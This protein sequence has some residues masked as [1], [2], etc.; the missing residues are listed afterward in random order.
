MGES[1]LI[2]VEELLKRVDGKKSDID[3]KKE[4]TD[5]KIEY[6]SRYV[7]E[8]VRVGVNSSKIHRLNFI[9]C[10]SNSGIYSDGNLSTAACVFEQFCAQAKHHPEKEFNLVINDINPKRVELCTAVCNEL[11]LE[12]DYSGDNLSL[13]TSNMDVNEFLLSLDA[14]AGLIDGYGILTLIFVDPYNAHTVDA[15]ILKEYLSTHYCELF[16]N[17]FSM[18]HVRN[19]DSRAIRDCFEGVE[20]PPGKDAG[21][22]IADWLKG[23]QIRYSFNYSFHNSSN[24][25]IYQI[26]FLTPNISGLE[27]LKAA[28]WNV[29]SGRQY[30]RNS[31][32]LGYQTSIFDL[33]FGQDMLKESYGYQAGLVLTE[34]FTGRTVSYA[35]VEEVVLQRSM[36][37]K[38]DVIKWV[39]KPLINSNSVVKLNRGVR[40]SNY[41]NDYFM[42]RD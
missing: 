14:H 4:Q 16:F 23:G 29:F 35:E 8:W 15:V 10:M 5:K 36:L 31:K 40:S 26:I 39:L 18:D 19:K 12:S 9:D 34:R 38:N 25:E 17:W 41:T 33:D 21:D 13:Y 28:L 22:W 32:R 20:V 37:G 3:D 7:E 24:A 42:F 30:H 6:I 2:S 27:K 1:Q 11:L